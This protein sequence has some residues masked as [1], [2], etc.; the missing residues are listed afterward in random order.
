MEIIETITSL[1]EITAAAANSPIPDMLLVTK[2]ATDRNASPAALA[3]VA[4]I[5]ETSPGR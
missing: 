4:T 1:N 5:A 3:C 2:N